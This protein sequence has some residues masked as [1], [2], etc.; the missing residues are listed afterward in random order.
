MFGAIKVTGSI[1]YKLSKN[2]VVSRENEKLKI[3]F[4]SF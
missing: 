4:F 1:K 2:C 3:V